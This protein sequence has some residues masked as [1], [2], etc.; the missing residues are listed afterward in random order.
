MRRN[1]LSASLLV[2]VSLMIGLITVCSGQAVL[3]DFD[4]APIHT[5]LPID[6]TA[7]GVTARLWG[8]G[9]GYSIQEANTMGFTPQ[10][11]GGLCI[12]PNSINLAD[13]LIRFDR[14]L[15][16]FSILY[17]CQEL[18]CDDAA[19]M[20]VT[21]Y[22]AGTYVGT[23]TKTASQPGTWPTDTLRCSFAEGFDS[24]VV[25][26]AQR[27]PT[28]QDYGV[29]FL[30]DNMRIT[31]VDTAGVKEDNAGLVKGYRLGQNYPNP[32]NSSTS[33]SF[34]L[35]V[36]STVRLE[37][38]DPTGKLVGLPVCGVVAAGEHSTTWEAQTASGVFFY[39][40]TAISNLDDRQSVRLMKKMLMMR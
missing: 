20:R 21:A 5:G 4:N 15:N 35:P 32:F 25:H 10:G 13:L 1:A 19:T 16:D 18:G 11:M 3:F 26:Y 31:A 23:N 12:Y 8:T 9:Q 2:A 27:P 39:R 24:V 40:L 22:R 7:G 34:T 6:Q 29:I 36:P 30:A 17:A 38:F 14:P 28:C 33:I 37:I